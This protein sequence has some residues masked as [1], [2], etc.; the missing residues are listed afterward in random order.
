VDGG[1][2]LDAAIARFHIHHPDRALATRR[3]PDL[4]VVEVDPAL[5]RRVLDNLLDNA[6]KFSE[7]TDAIEVEARRGPP[8]PAAEPL[9]IRVRDRGIGIPEEDLPR[10]FEPFFRTDRSRARATGGVGLGLAIARRVL[11]AHG[12]A[13]WVE[14]SPHEGTRFTIEIPQHAAQP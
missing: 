2:L 10:V 4:P 8:G 7:P 5:M 1:K 11:E 12:A 6:V 3:D 14:S 13:I 9:V